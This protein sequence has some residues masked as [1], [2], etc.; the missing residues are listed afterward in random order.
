MPRPP[1]RFAQPMRTEAPLPGRLDTS[2]E[3]RGSPAPLR[4]ACAMAELKCVPAAFPSLVASPRLR[5]PRAVPA[6]ALIAAL[7]WQ[8]V[9]DRFACAAGVSHSETVFDWRAACSRK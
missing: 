6:P 3:V 5:N 2:D 1:V 7:A 8:S 9:D 4:S